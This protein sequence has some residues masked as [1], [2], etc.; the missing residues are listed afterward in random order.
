MNPAAMLEQTETDM[1]KLVEEIDR[2]L[3]AVD[4]FRAADC[5][6]TWRPE[7]HSEVV[8]SSVP[9]TSR[10]LPSDIRLH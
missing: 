2:Y 9:L 6:P 1:R 8:V 3:A 5:E 4:I 10:Q 7:I